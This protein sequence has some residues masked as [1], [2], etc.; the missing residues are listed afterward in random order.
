[1]GEIEMAVFKSVQVGKTIHYVNLDNITH[2]EDNPQHNRMIIFFA[3]GP[4][5]AADGG[6]LGLFSQPSVKCE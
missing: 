3:G 5:L 1:M 2:I 4:T 6:A